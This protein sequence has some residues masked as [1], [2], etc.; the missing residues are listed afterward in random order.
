MFNLL[1]SFF[2]PQVVATP[3]SRQNATDL[4][5][6][7][8]L[9]Q[10]NCRF[11]GLNRLYICYNGYVLIVTMELIKPMPVLV[12]LFTFNGR[13]SNIMDVP[14]DREFTET[15]L[16]SIL[17]LINFSINRDEFCI[18]SDNMELFKLVRLADYVGMDS[19][20]V[21]AAK[22][23]EVLPIQISNSMGVRKVYKLIRDRYR[24]SENNKKGRCTIC[25]GVFNRDPVRMARSPC[26]QKSYHPACG[27]RS[28]TRQCQGCKTP[29]S[30][31][32]C[33][34]CLEL[35][36]RGVYNVYDNYVKSLHHRTP[37]CGA[38]YHERCWVDFNNRG[39]PLYE[40]CPLCR[41]PIKNGGVYLD[42]RH[43]GHV[44]AGRKI[45]QQNDDRRVSGHDLSVNYERPQYGQW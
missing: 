6:P 23:L 44:M 8:I 9:A 30:L 5:L 34:F 39:S 41:N 42:M 45:T 28:T 12:A 4:P 35:I 17:R 31:L 3:I 20:L 15:P 16:T 26:C 24:A 13:K 10:Q 27:G 29:L 33:L 2:T 14:V 22:W 21:G 19:F 11:L 25:T 18:P 7:L 32:P 43:L 37:C 1:D 40:E 38:D 36:E